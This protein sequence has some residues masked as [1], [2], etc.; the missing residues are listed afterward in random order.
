MMIVIYLAHPLCGAH[1]MDAGRDKV[2]AAPLRRALR[3]PSPV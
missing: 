1:E 3:L 2:A